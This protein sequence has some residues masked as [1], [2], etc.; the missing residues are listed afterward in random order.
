MA[1]YQRQH[2]DGIEN[3]RTDKPYPKYAVRWV[4]STNPENE[5]YIV[6][7]EIV[8]VALGLIHSS[9]QVVYRTKSEDEADMY[10]RFLNKQDEIERN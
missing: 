8:D 1:I 2:A 10:C 6:H 4:T 7:Y 5:F 9:D 3:I